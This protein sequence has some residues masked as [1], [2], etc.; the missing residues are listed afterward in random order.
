MTPVLANQKADHCH[1]DCANPRGENTLSEAN[2]VN[3]R[4]ARVRQCPQEARALTQ[5]VVNTKQFSTNCFTLGTNLDVPVKQV[6]R[7]LKV[8]LLLGSH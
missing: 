4:S 1:G 2:S 5:R 8:R 3:W 7:G 6:A